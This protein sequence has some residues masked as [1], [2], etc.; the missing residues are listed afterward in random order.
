MFVDQI[1]SGIV[2]GRELSKKLYG[3]NSVSGQYLYI[4][5]MIPSDS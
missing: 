2:N 4:L 3:L 5:E 1:Y